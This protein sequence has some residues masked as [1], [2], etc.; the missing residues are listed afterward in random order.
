MTTEL[1]NHRIPWSAGV[2]RVCCTLARTALPSM[3]TAVLLISCATEDDG[4]DQSDED[5]VEL[6]PIEEQMR[7]LKQAHP[8]AEQLSD[9]E[10]S[11]ENGAVILKLSDPT[12][13]TKPAH[14]KRAAR[15]RCDANH[16]CVYQNAN[17]GG[18][19]LQFRDC[20]E[21]GYRNNL[22][23]WARDLGDNGFINRTSSSVNNLANSRID[24]MDEHRLDRD[25]RL[26]IMGQGSRS[27]YPA[28]GQNDNKA[29][30]L[31]CYRVQ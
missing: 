6:M 14:D 4:A 18:R 12:G 15:H 29:D 3:F 23:S 30:Y 19:V 26:W 20:T 8:E 13:E 9:T 16:Y 24:V 17:Y 5:A 31:V 10:L 7:R 27:L 11:F 1:A 25:D 21:N 22:K 28:A 2:M